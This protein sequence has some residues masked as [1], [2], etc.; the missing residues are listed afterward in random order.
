MNKV[1]RRPMALLATVVVV[2]QAVSLAYYLSDPFAIGT[3]PGLSDYLYFFLVAAH[4][5]W[6]AGIALPIARKARRVRIGLLFRGPEVLAGGTLVLFLFVFIYALNANMDYAQR[7][8]SMSGA[9]RL[10]PDTTVERANAVLRFL[11][12]ILANLL[13]YLYP[14]LAKRRLSRRVH[15]AGV[16]APWGLPSAVVSALL[17]A[18]AL[19]SLFVL[20]GLPFLAFVCLVPLFATLVSGPRRWAVFYG[21]LFGCVQT[22][23]TNYWLATYG[24]ISLQFIVV[25][26]LA[27]Y[28]VFMALSVPLVRAFGATG[29][30]WLPVTWVVFD[31]LRSVGFLGYPWAMLGTAL[32]SVPVLTQIAS[33]FGV[34][35]VTFL[36]LFANA[37][38]AYVV[39]R[40][41]RR[42]RVRPA[43]PA[44]AAVLVV[45]TLAFGLP[46]LVAVRNEPKVP[47]VRVALIQQNTDPRKDDY[48]STFSV[49]TRLTD[50]ALRKSPDLVAWSETAFVPNIRR[51]G[52]MDPESHPLA[53]LV[54]RFRDYQQSI[55]TWLVTGND[56]YVLETDAAGQTVRKDYNAAVLFS[57]EGERVETYHK[58]N[59]VPFTEDFPFREQ[60]PWVYQLL[61]QFDVNL[62]ERGHRRVVL[63]HPEFAFSTPICFEDG[64]PNDVRRFVRAGAQ[65]I[66]NL[67]NDYWSLTEVEAKQHV[68]NSVFR[69]IENN[70]PLLRA[71]ASGETCHIDTAGRI[72]ATIPYYEEGYL[73]TDVALVERAGTVYTALGDWLPAICG[74]AVSVGFI[75]IAIRR[76]PASLEQR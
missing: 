70:R 13:V 23:I 41:L 39:V 10:A 61:I 20:E 24:L 35:G 5:A 2:L 74:L 8:A 63:H 73:V 4:L 25:V 62:W 65:V 71:T 46:R 40:G 19:P 44:T 58:I 3:A 55:G 22:M 21:V 33:V 6:A 9:L 54:H 42:R 66:L 49:L 34:W 38:L 69:A 45:L 26:Y 30:L 12:L 37:A 36:V 17:Y 56:D 64:F 14:R 59:L 60:L 48:S 75:Y 15:G 43:V 7:F 18:A 53:R 67:S 32:Y 76:R 47:S 57:A 27:W 28:L 29:L 72:I 51:W 11:P 50:E 52:A 16:F 1:L 68:A 31:Y